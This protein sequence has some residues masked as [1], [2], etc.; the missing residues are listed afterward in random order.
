MTAFKCF[1][2]LKRVTEDEEKHR[3]DTCEELEVL[4]RASVCIN[5]SKMK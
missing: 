4:K 1:K 3:L 2:L 5:F